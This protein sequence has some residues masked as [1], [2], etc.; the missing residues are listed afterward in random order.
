MTAEQFARSVKNRIGQLGGNFM[1]SQEA[2]AKGKELGTGGWGTYMLGRG[3]VLG[4]GGPA[5][6]AA[7]FVFFPLEYV[8]NGW[9]RARAILTPEEMVKHY[10]DINA[11]WSRNH[12]SKAEG[13]ERLGELLAKVVA[14]APIDGIPLFAGWKAQPLP[15]DPVERLGQL[16]FALR[17]YRM[18]CHGIA[19]LA[20]GV[21]PYQAVLLGGGPGNAAFFGYPEPHPDVEEHRAKYDASEEITD[22]LAARAWRVLDESERTECAAL[23]EAA[24]EV[25]SASVIA[26]SQA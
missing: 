14:D 23:L 1:M 20:S 8:A 10:L 2:K 5:P 21:T 24:G 17:E 3:G 9:D 19:V 6:V 16:A 13:V 11:S 7:A 26:S 25:A 18:G 12:L 4:D 15:T 22:R